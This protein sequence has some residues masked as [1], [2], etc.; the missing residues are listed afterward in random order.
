[1]A[2]AQEALIPPQETIALEARFPQAPEER[3]FSAPVH[4][5][6]L[7]HCHFRGETAVIA[8]RQRNCWRSWPP[9]RQN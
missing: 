4:P 7:P 2:T 3:H 5:A 6:S 8:P 1:M 9:F